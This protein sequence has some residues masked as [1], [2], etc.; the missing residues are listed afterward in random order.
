M[1]TSSNESKFFLSHL[2]NTQK[3][4]EY[5]SGESTFEIAKKV[6]ELIS[7]EHDRKW[8]NKTVLNIPSNCKL[9]LNE[10][11]LF[12]PST[13]PAHDGTFEE[14]KD[15]IHSPL[16][17]APF[18]VIF[19]DGRARVACAEISQLLG[20]SETIVFIHDFDRVE[21]NEVLKYLTLL[22]RVDN[23]AKFKIIWK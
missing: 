15:Y 10:P 22:E 21:Y 1:F 14:F 8:Y 9:I 2:T 5:G 23:M 17:L 19:I 6:K 18:D 13:G 3:V 4:L 7:I 16:P 20:H 12:Y 11:N